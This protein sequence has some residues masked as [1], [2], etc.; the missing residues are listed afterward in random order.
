MM[1]TSAAIGR[2]Q[3][4]HLEPCEGGVP[5]SIALLGGVGGDLAAARLVQDLG[6]VLVSIS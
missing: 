3:M 5:P 6:L 2:E 4:G 1:A